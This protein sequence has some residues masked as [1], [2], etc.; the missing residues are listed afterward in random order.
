MYIKQSSGEEF[1]GKTHVC[2]KS[3]LKYFNVCLIFK[4]RDADV[5]LFFNTTLLPCTSLTS[6][7]NGTEPQAGAIIRDSHLVDLVYDQIHGKTSVQVLER[8][9]T[10]V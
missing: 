6:V 7:H 4:Q 8:S 10:T 2:I 5:S 1:R 3:K 9:I